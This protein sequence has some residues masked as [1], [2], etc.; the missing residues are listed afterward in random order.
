MNALLEFFDTSL[1]QHVFWTLLHSIWQSALI[2]M[3]LLTCLSFLPARRSRLRY[4]LAYGALVLVVLSSAITHGIIANADSAN[5]AEYSIAMADSR[6]H[7]SAIV[8]ADHAGVH[9]NDGDLHLNAVDL[10]STDAGQEQV[11]Q[12]SQGWFQSTST[13]AR[14]WQPVAIAVWLA[15]SCVLLLRNL[16][17]VVRTEKLKA[18][19]EEAPSSIQIQFKKLKDRLNCTLPVEVKISNSESLFSPC[20]FGILRATVVVPAAMLTQLTSDEIESVLAHELAHI[21]RYDFLFNLLQLAIGSLYF[22]N[23]AIYLINRQIR[24]EREACC[25]AAAVKAASSDMAYAKTLSKFAEWI[26]QKR[27]IDQPAMAMSFTGSQNRKLLDR[28]RRVLL[29][30]KTP[31]TISSAWGFLFVLLGTFLVLASTSSGTKAIASYTSALIQESEVRASEINEMKK[32]NAPPG[33][34]K[35]SGKIVLRILNDKGMPVDK[36]SVFIVSILNSKSSSSSANGLRRGVVDQEFVVP[37]GVVSL[38]LD[39]K[40]FAPKLVLKD[41]DLYAGK[42]IEREVQLTLGQSCRLK[43]SDT[44]GQPIANALIRCNV[45]PAVMSTSSTGA[46]FKTDEKG[47]ANV[48]NLDHDLIDHLAVWKSGYVTSQVK[49]LEREG[50]ISVTLERK[51]VTKG[52]VVD[53]KGTPVANAKIY[54]GSNGGFDRDYSK[55]IAITDKDGKYETNQLSPGKHT[56]IIEQEKQRG[57]VENV[58]AGDEVQL[59]LFKPRSIKVRLKGDLDFFDRETLQAYQ[60]HR[61]GSVHGMN[62]VTAFFDLPLDMDANN[63]REFSLHGVVSGSLR[64]TQSGKTLFVTDN[65]KEMPDEIVIDLDVFKVKKRAAK[66]VFEFGKQRAFPQGTIRLYRQSPA[67]KVWSESE[68]VEIKDGEVDVMVSSDKLKVEPEGMTGFSI[69]GKNRPSQTVKL[70]NGQFVVNVEPAGAIHGMVLDSKGKPLATSLR[71]RIKFH[72]ESR[73]GFFYDELKTNS[74]AN[75]KFVLTPI[76]LGVKAKIYAGERLL[77]YWEEAELNSN[78]AVA[79][80]SLRLPKSGSAKVRITD[81]KGNPLHKIQVSIRLKKVSTHS[82]YTD[83]DGSRVVEGLK[84]GERGYQLEI[85]PRRDFQVPPSRQISSGDAFDIVL[86]EGHRLSGKVV[87][88]DGLPVEE[89]KVSASFGDQS[90]T[91]DTLTNAKG[92]FSFTRLPSEPVTLQAAHR[93]KQIKSPVSKPYTPDKDSGIVLTVS[94]KKR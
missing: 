35:G 82:F 14:Q 54:G 43:V 61:A 19:T 76:P 68:L 24:L 33:Q 91:A 46:K 86:K 89:F 8:E 80:V 42:T 63:D 62:R 44:E 50:V 29:P 55:P 3:V 49:N 18:I 67:T 71:A 21:K 84:V 75:G 87:D 41:V 13:I 5:I 36:G 48:L 22:F 65:T 83:K 39:I 4:A 56:L 93:W 73:S 34:Q 66:I 30:E 31:Y 88:S 2:A 60:N 90:I 94:E 26:H 64:I 74:K 40:G 78:K 51:P 77:N 70:E 28:V 53:H 25:D 32:K 52:I 38:S 7:D 16:V 15:I 47:G 57:I 58:V 85:D 72:D 9:S 79:E 92:E 59:A 37:A 6:M 1:W 27:N 10:H 17:L 20:V 12:S 23:P 69:I 11:A 81:S 45:D